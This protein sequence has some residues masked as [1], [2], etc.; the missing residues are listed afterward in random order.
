LDVK[1]ATF[2]WISEKWVGNDGVGSMDTR[3]QLS[4]VKSLLPLFRPPT[5]FISMLVQ[6]LMGSCG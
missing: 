1:E 6:I 4:I 5:Q 3:L 2:V